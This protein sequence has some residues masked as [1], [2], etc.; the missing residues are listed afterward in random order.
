MA[1]HHPCY[2]CH[3]AFYVVLR[4]PP[5]VCYTAVVLYDDVQGFRSLRKHI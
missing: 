1:E 4:V 2:A 5:R 3:D